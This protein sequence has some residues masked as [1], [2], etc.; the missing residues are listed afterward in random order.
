MARDH[1]L[2][3]VPQLDDTIR[4]A[5]ND[6]T[7]PLL[8]HA[9][10]VRTGP[11]PRAATWCLSPEHHCETLESCAW[12]ITRSQAIIKG[13]PS[14]SFTTTEKQGESE[15]C[16][17]W[18][19]RQ[20]SRSDLRYKPMRTEDADY[21]IMKNAGMES[22]ANLVF[23]RVMKAPPLTV[24]CLGGLLYAFVA[25]LFGCLLFALGKDCYYEEE[26]HVKFSFEQTLHMSVQI[27]AT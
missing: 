7:Q 24:I 6:G 8:Q 1:R 20:D 12:T 2:A 22:I 26:D 3:V 9:H 10:V 18:E 13:L 23:D 5:S 19:W 11:A 21:V 17:Y 14:S 15:T 27:F 25:F 16:H 4:D